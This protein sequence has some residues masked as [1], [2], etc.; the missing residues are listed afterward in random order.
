[1]TFERRGDPPVEV[2]SLLPQEGAVGDILAERVL[3]GIDGVGASAVAEK[4][5]GAHEAVQ[6]SDEIGFVEPG[7]LPDQGVREF[8]AD[9]GARLNDIVFARNGAPLPADMSTITGHFWHGATALVLT[10][11]IA[12]HIA[13]AVR[14]RQVMARMR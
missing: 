10:L 12:L 7:D 13:G 8:A 14:D 4:E 6:R 5:A 3:E 11:L 2:P 1:M 9:G